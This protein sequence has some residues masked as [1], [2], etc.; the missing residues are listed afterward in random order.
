MTKTNHNIDYQ[1]KRE[2][3]LWKLA[4]IANQS[5]LT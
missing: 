1:E 3:Y 2:F 5:D 4:K